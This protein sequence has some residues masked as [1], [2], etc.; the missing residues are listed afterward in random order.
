[1]ARKDNFNDDDR[2][3]S[4]NDD[5]IELLSEYDDEFEDIYSDSSRDIYSDSSKD[6]YIGNKR[7]HYEV[8][9]VNIDDDE[10]DNVY[11]NSKGRRIVIDSEII[12]ADEKSS[13]REI[14]KVKPETPPVKR[15]KK[16]IDEDEVSDFDDRHSGRATKKISPLKSIISLLL[17]AVI[18]FGAVV[19]LMASSVV[20]KFKEGTEIEHIADADSLASASHVRNI[21]LIGSDK[22][23]GDSSRSD[24]IMIASVN[25]KTG[26]ITLVS[27]LRDTHVDI[28]DKRESKINAAYSWGG[29]DLLI[30]TIEQNFG[31]KID[32][33]ATVDFEMFEALVEGIGGIYVD[34]SEN[35]ADYMNRY[36]K[37]GT[38][39]NPPKI[40]SGENVY[41]NGY[42]ALCYARIRKLDSDFYRTERQR[43]I[44]SAIVENVKGDLNPV[45]VFKLLETAGEVAP[46]IETT[47]TQSD[48][49]SLLLKCGSCLLKS[50]GNTE[51]LLVSE[52]LPFD[53]TWWY[54]NEWDGSSISIDLEENRQILYDKL[55]G[56][57]QETTEETTQENQ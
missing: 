32:D 30:Q 39:D 43:K 11:V 31:I 42:H 26:K 34:V 56:E 8:V 13:T 9:D 45:G 44:I 49:T 51:K 38:G 5:Y 37:L 19:F 29:S 57:V 24:T 40:E 28:P 52:K 6:V 14:R 15:A 16:I 48:V 21:L 36:F 55:Y 12:E 3:I 17:V 35:E 54:S 25:S 10:E 27:I 2:K 1:M 33:Y 41:L 7:R 23:T 4:V 50:G 47:L 46:Y 18:A 22:K 20:G 53:G